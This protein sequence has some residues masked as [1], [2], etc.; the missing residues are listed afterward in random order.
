MQDVEETSKWEIIWNNKF[1]K[2]GFTH[3]LL[4]FKKKTFLKMKNSIF[5][6]NMR[7]MEKIL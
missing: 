4:W 5:Q 1:Y 6:K 2:F 7:D 3:F